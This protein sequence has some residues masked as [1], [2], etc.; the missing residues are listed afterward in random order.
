[1]FCTWR[2][3]RNGTSFHYGDYSPDYEYA[4]ESFAK[5]SGLIAEKKIFPIN[6]I[7]DFYAALKYTKEHCDELDYHDERRIY[8]L[9]E[10]LC[11]DFPQIKD[12]DFSF[13]ED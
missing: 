3:N 1:M 2:Q 6:E 5:R 8:L 4:K 11:K 10:K 12:I 7:F 9:M 13:S